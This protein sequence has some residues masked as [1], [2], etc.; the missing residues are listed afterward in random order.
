MP[1]E[2][3]PD[4]PES[5]FH[6]PRTRKWLVRCAG[7]RLIGYRPNTPVDAFN[8]YWMERKLEPLDLDDRGL[9]ETCRAALDRPL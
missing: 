9:C 5:Y 7:C 8:R 2:F 4:D 1:K 3:L 6:D